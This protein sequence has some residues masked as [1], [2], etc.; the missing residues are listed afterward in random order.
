MV[1]QIVVSLSHE[2]LSNLKEQTMNICN[3]LHGSPL[4]KQEKRSI[5]MLHSIIVNLYNIIEMTKLLK[6]RTD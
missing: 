4:V 2:P 3:N 5:P 6:W 1:E